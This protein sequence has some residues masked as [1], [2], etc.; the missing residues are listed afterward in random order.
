ML[1]SALTTTGTECVMGSGE[2]TH[3]SDRNLRASITNDDYATSLKMTPI[4]EATAA[5]QHLRTA[6]LQCDPVCNDLIM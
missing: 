1:L 3:F 4:L 2:Q 5:E 6:I